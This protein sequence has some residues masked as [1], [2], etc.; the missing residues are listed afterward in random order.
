MLPLA[1]VPEHSF[2]IIGASPQAR[3]PN[4]RRGWKALRAPAIPDPEGETLL[5]A[6]QP[7]G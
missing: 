7:E 6:S 2:Q 1:T 5:N 3:R 4:S